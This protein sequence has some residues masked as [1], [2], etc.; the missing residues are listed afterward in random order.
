M[1]Q[2][3][4][5]KKLF[6]VFPDAYINKNNEVIISE[7][8]NVFFSLSDVDSNDGLSHKIL[9]WCSRDACKSMPY[10]SEKHNEKHH[11]FIRQGC[12]KILGKELTEDDWW[13]IYARLGNNINPELAK[14]FIESDFDMSVLKED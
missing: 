12:N 9:S 4:Y 8:G 11:V 13:N 3:D 14:R 10:K 5:I 1:E 7:K 6:D 2:P